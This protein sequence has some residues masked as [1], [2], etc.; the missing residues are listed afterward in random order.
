ML[1]LCPGRASWALQRAQPWT[2]GRRDTLYEFQGCSHNL[3]LIPST[4]DRL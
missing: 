4:P 1:Q 3:G 2:E